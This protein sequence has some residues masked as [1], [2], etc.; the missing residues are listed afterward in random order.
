V[1]TPPALPPH[2]ARDVLVRT[3][4]GGGFATRAI[5]AGQ[6][7]EQTTGAVIVPIYQTSTFATDAVGESRAGYDY[8]RAGNPTRSAFETAIGS[9][10]G[11]KHGFAFASG[12]A[13]TDTLLRAT[14]RPGDH[15]ILPDDAYGGTWRLVN[16][17]LGPWGI[18]H[19]ALPLSNLDAVRA[20]V[21]PATKMIIAE[22]PTNPLLNIFDIAGLAQIADDA[23]ALLAVD[24][25]FA[26]PYLQN[27]LALGAHVVLHSTT[28]Y[29][30]GHSDVIGGAIVTDNNDLGVKI[31][32]HSKSMGGAAAPF[33]TW[34]ALRGLKTLELR[35]EKHCDNAEKIAEMLCSH[36]KVAEV[37]YPGLPEHKGHAIAA[38]QMRRFGGMI[39]FR[40]KGGKKDALR[41][42]AR[43]Q[44]FLLAESLGGVESLIEH[45]GLMTHMSVAG[46]ILEV[47]DDLIRL[48]VGIEDVEDLLEDLSGALS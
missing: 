12:M 31:T 45:P 25:T 34:L 36:P 32:F 28:K 11:G 24:N 47:P 2:P 7:P 6:D 27:P 39:S 15:V 8:S 35:M 17:V 19:T 41:I 23:G 3:A 13:A 4:Q 22:T 33:D 40:V 29:I 43:T 5:H 10:E 26:T 16:T 20:A 48:S 21:T 38:S 37:F 30:G 42:C 44:V 9:L 14:L 1:T 46:S 18:T